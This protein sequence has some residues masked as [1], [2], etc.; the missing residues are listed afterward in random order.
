[1]IAVI[2]VPS[3]QSE[4]TLRTRQTV[5][6]RLSTS[7][8]LDSIQSKAKVDVSLRL[9]AVSLLVGW[10]WK[11]FFAVFLTDII[12][13]EVT[14]RKKDPNGGDYVKHYIIFLSFLVPSVALLQRR[15]VLVYR[16]STETDELSGLSCWE[17][18]K[19]WRHS[20]EPG[21]EEA[22]AATAEEDLIVVTNPTI[23]MEG[24]KH[25]NPSG[26][27]KSDGEIATV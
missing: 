25:R 11:N 6:R 4:R 7:E 16:E 26:M 22:Q 19:R 10:A 9:T 27:S 1:M 14:N 18:F 23:E 24:F 13:S 5:L 20:N 3:L 17:H 8:D 15:W 21:P 12:E 2:G